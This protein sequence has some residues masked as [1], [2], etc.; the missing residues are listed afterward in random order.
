M[1]Y[2]YTLFSFNEVGLEEQLA[3]AVGNP[4]FSQQTFLTIQDGTDGPIHLVSGF[5]VHYTDLLL[6]KLCKD[7]GVICKILSSKHLPM[8]GQNLI[9][10]PEAYDAE[11]I[12][13][14]HLC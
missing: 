11:G 3:K 6:Y 10:R 4:L 13:A 14:G 7:H 5:Q 12:C 9:R 2:F 1:P 8:G